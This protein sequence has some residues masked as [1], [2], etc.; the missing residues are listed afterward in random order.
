MKFVFLHTENIHKPFKDLKQKKQKKNKSNQKLMCIHPL[1][2]IENVRLNLP[3]F[4]YVR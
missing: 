1:S 3:V 2:H 4:M